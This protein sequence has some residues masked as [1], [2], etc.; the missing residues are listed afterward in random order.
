MKILIEAKCLILNDSKKFILNCIFLT[1][2]F[3]EMPDVVLSQVP[4]QWRGYN[5]DGIYNEEQLLNRWPE[6]GPEM[7]WFTEEIGAGFSSP[8]VT[9]DKLFVNGEI[10]S[11][12][13]LF[14][15]NLQG[16]L[17]WKAPNGREFFGEDYS[18]SFPGA[19]STPTVYNE[20]V[21][22]CSGNGRIACFEVLTGKEQWSVEMVKDLGG[23]ENQFGYSESLLV[24][25]KYVYCF[26]GGGQTNFA[27][28]DR[29]TGKTVWVSKAL[30]DKV[31]FCS[32][33]FINIQGK[34]ILVTLSREYLL[35][36]DCSNGELLWSQ[37]QDSVAIEG[38]H[39]NTPVYADGCIY[40]TSGDK[41]GNGAVKLAISA[42]GKVIRE[43]WRNRRI[44]DAFGGFVIVGNYLYSTVKA[45][46]LKSLDL[47]NG[48]V[49]DSLSN[50][51]GSIIYADRL[52]Y[53]HTIN[54]EV[55][56]IQPANSGKLGLISK[57][58]IDKG[59]QEHFS[60][61]VIA[62]GV[63]Y[64]RHG[65]ALMA[66]DIRKSKVNREDN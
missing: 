55:K 10:D 2:L 59:S 56:L 27:A 32:P 19:R 20:S 14:V 4:A 46:K 39:C 47:E 58:K 11:I 60:H 57:F 3:F 25:E 16:K 45:N 6:K 65:K 1:L 54:G 40:Y 28:L 49:V 7:L 34:K 53:C 17:L 63:L 52:L 37:K 36:I 9:K 48:S 61:P 12:S 31:S 29:F 33:T 41:N 62:G 35:G 15:F 5:R 64:I 44:D 18:K 30:G 50:V 51:R 66:Y 23:R 22:V 38:E 24:D 26:P 43:V 42:N 8:S 21:Y 13:H